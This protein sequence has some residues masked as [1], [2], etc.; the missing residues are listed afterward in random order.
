MTS[1]IVVFGS[2][3]LDF[4]F[5]M[6][7]LP[8]PGQT[9]LAR[10]LSVQP[11]GKGANQAA[12]ARLA[13][14]SVCMVG[15]VGNDELADPALAVMAR[16]GVDLSAL[17]RVPGARTGCASIGTDPQGRNQ[18]SVAL[19]ANAEL[20]STDLPDALLR[21]G[22]ILLAQMET[23]AAQVA[24]VVERAQAAGMFV[25]LNLAPMHILPREVLRRLSLLVVNEDEAEA[26][27]AE[28]G[29]APSAA[30]LRGELGITV[31]RT[32][33]RDGAEAAEPNGTPRVHA[34]TVQAV[35]TTAAGDCFVGTLA[36]ELYRKQPLT[37]ALER[38]CAAAAV[39]CTRHG[40]QI[41]LPS[42]TEVAAFLQRV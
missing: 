39:A 18:I 17:R 23:E 28:L 15:A 1:D 6:D 33:G 26:L 30:A 36:W 8:G 2:I 19:G 40:S 11:G 14:A 16:A 21:P 3:N 24:A 4:I 25:V 12:A 13:G 31:V 42:A 20:R 37:A 34:P 35:D 9:R 22:A 38:A 32:L 41:S 10:S 7:A 27:A 29:S 5:Q